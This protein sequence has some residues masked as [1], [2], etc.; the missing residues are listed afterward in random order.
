MRKLKDIQTPGE[1][2][3]PPRLG[4][5]LRDS[6][7]LREVLHPALEALKLPKAGMHI[8]SWLQ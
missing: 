7:V 4:T 6:N 3:F 5:P 1:L 8:S 2:I